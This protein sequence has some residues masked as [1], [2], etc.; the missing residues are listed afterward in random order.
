MTLD[1]TAITGAIAG[2]G[3]VGWMIYEKN[4]EKKAV[5]KERKMLAEADLD[6]NPTRCLIH[7]RAINEI[8]ADIKLIKTK[9]DIV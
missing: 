5:E 7:Q 9:L 1:P 8:R 4:R 3:A 6:G 2:L